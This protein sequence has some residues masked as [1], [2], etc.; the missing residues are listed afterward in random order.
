M[1]FSA[2]NQI[3]FLLLWYHLP[4]NIHLKS[5][6]SDLYDSNSSNLTNLIEI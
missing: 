5:G 3:V 1:L 6:Y 2:F 4:L